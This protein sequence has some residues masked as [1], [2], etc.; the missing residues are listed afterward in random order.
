[1]HSYNPA[2]LL[3]GIYPEE[4]KTYEHIQIFIAVLFVIAKNWK[5]KSKCLSASE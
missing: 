1:M 4:I 3:L 5:K 2:M